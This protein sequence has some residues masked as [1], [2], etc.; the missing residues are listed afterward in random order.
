MGAG[1]ESELNNVLLIFCLFPIVFFFFWNGVVLLLAALGGW[2]RLAEH[3]RTQTS[4]EGT[5]WSFKSGRMGFTNYNGCL[6]IGANSAGLYLAVMPLFRA[7]HAPL[8]VPW[9]DITTAPSRRF[10]FS[11]LNFNFARLPSVTLKLPEKMGETVLTLRPD[12]YAGE[13]D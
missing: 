4:F 5:R 10:F 8:F 9:E 3:Y 13:P 6:T 1:N 11:Y 7:G 2:S 12:F